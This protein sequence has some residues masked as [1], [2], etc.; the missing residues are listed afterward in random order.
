VDDACSC[1][2]HFTRAGITASNKTSLREAIV[3]HFELAIRRLVKKWVH[4]DGIAASYTN[5]HV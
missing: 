1:D 5:E 2:R 3:L 4:V